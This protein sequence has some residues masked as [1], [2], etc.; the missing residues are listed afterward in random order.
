[1]S[2]AFFLDLAKY[3]SIGGTALDIILKMVAAI[4]QIKARG[5]PP[6]DQELHQIALDS[7]ADFEA[8]PKPEA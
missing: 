8:L 3:L 6:T 7:R 1:M 5:R 4:S 2:A